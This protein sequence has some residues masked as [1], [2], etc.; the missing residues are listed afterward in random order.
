MHYPRRGLP[1]DEAE[2]AKLVTLDG[3]A[4]TVLD[5]Y[6]CR[7]EHARTLGAAARATLNACRHDLDP[8]QL[9]NDASRYF[10][11]LQQII[12]LVLADGEPGGSERQPVAGEDS[13]RA[14][15]GR[16]G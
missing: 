13:L 6:F 5:Q 4:G 8:S 14:R 3:M 2:R 12:E 10:G 9:S 11:R 1:A 15:C 16:P 7:G